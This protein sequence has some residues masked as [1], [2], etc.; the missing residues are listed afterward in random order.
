MSDNGLQYEILA[1]YPHD[2]TSFT[3]G[4]LYHNGFIYE[5]TGLHGRSSVRKIRFENGEVLQKYDLPAEYFGEGIVQWKSRLFQLTWNSQIGF[6]YDLDTLNRT[7]EFNYCGE[8]WGL[9]Q[10]GKQLIMSDGSS[11]LYLW[12][13][14]TLK[15]IG[16]IPVT[17]N[18]VPVTF[19]NDL[20]WV[21]GEIFANVLKS[22]A[23]ARIDAGS[24][25][26]KGW[27]DLGMIVEDMQASPL[28]DAQAASKRRFLNG[29]AYDP[30]G[31]RLFVTGK[32]WPRLFAI[33]LVSS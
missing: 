23:I 13:P 1:S 18:G 7:G 14:E 25:R 21:N 20:E 19:I 4:L 26:V 27:L 8:G 11:Q 31:K 22:P 16:R 15:E 17:D 5:A 10:D 24:G 33:K 32:L 6:I 12:N 28:Q 3:Q 9:C 2:P 30:V 29:I